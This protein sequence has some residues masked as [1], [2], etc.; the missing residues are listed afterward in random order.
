M[1]VCLAMVPFQHKTGWSDDRIGELLAK[2]KAETD[3]TNKHELLCEM[4]K[5]VAENAPVAIP[6]HRN[7]VDGI[8]DKVKGLPRL[9]LG[10]RGAA[11]W[12]EFVW[13]DA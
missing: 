6:S 2:A 5:I 3:P 11:E 9:S 8:S 4:Q 1:K 7:I 12:P 10:G 13:F